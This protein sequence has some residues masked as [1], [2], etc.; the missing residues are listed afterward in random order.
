MNLL[1]YLDRQIVPAVQ[2]SIKHSS[3]QPS[4]TQLGALASAFLIVYMIA[5]PF[6]GV[7]GDRIPR[8][9]IVA[10]GVALWSL[11]T[12][13]GGLAPN[14]AT[15]FASRAFVGIGEAAYGTVAPALLADAFPER[16]RGR[17]FGIFYMAIPV[18]SALGY[19]LG[20][21]IDHAHGWR[22]AFFV[23]GIPG[24]ILAL[25]ALTLHDPPR[26]PGDATAKVGFQ[27]YLSF[28]R[29]RPYV[30]TVLGYAAYT[31]A[32]GGIAIWMPT[33]L[34]RVRGV[35]RVDANLNLGKVLVITGFA[36]T[37]L[38]SWLVDRLAKRTRQA[39]M[40]VSGIP[41]LA[42]A[43][44]AY[45]AL[46]TANPTTYWAALIG[47]ELLV[48]MSTGPVNVAIVS[49]VPPATR[50]AAM[51]LSIFV[52]HT[53][54]DVPSPPLIG[55]LSD[56]GSLAHAM[57]IIPVAVA[58]AGVIWTYAALTAARPRPQTR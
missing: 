32:L 45:L 35:P 24:L 41:T 44:L 8:Q 56:H 18:G 48:F 26:A 12:V 53:L 7:L 30:L 16:M 50:A 52:I 20:G 3:L 37:W 14:Y 28:T 55:W 15:L 54:G 17:I 39:A 51:A 21:A 19:V 34:E 22:A 11:A 10:V 31:F 1:N 6:V 46:T 2:E 33:F 29:I 23:A 47:A 13:C 42:A 57:L 25:I 5:A 36:G 58:V 9:K 38:G 4:D 40:W 49:D 43:P 27:T